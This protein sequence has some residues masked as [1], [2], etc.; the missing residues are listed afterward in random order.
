M[1]VGELSLG[2]VPPRP[3][4]VEV[5]SSPAV[6]FPIMELRPVRLGTHESE[7]IISDNES[8]LK[9]SIASPV[10]TGGVSDN[11]RKFDL[12][13]SWKT[14]SGKKVSEYKKL[15]EAID[16][17]RRGSLLRLIDIRIDQ[18]II[19]TYVHLSGKADP[20]RINFRRTVLLASQIEE[21]FSISLRM[22]E[23][24][25][26]TDAESLFHFDCLLNGSGYGKVA[27]GT[28]RLVKADGESGAAQESF[29]K[30]EFPATYTDAP[31]NY[32]GYFLLFSQRVATRE[33]VRVIEFTLADASTAVRA[34]SEAPIGSELSIEITAKGPVR[35]CWRDDLVLKNIEIG[36]LT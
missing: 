18:L 20:F 14:A 2:N 32:P 31:S 8:P 19:E 5:G 6:V 13:L 10:G 30:G 26:E 27:N 33:W 25:S 22:P 28:L 36:K 21:A 29:V 11:T 24:I 3:I 17:L 34:F 4:R 16:A 1:E 15:I 12:T 35:L 9:I 7:L 23:I